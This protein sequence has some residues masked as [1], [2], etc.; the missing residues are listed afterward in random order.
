MP[1]TSLTP[2]EANYLQAS[3]TRRRSESNMIQPAPGMWTIQPDDESSLLDDNVNLL[4]FTPGSSPGSTASFHT[5]AANNN[6]MHNHM[7]PHPQRPPHM[8]H[9][10]TFGPPSSTAAH[11][12]HPGS[13][14]NSTGL[15]PHLSANLMLNS[16]PHM[17]PSHLS[18][19]F[20]SPMDGAVQLRRARSD[21]SR[22]HRQVRSEDFNNFT[23][24]GV[25]QDYP[26]FLAP[27]IG[28]SGM[29]RAGH[30]RRA[31]SGSRSDRGLGVMQGGMI[32]GVWGN[33]A[34]SSPYPSPNASPRGPVDNIPLPD[35]SIRRGQRPSNIQ[36]D[37]H[38]VVKQNVTTHATKDAS[39][40]RRKVEA[41]FVCPVPGCG[42]T[43]TRHFNLKGQYQ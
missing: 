27:D 33:S 13:A 31:S 14:S 11:L 26:Q 12:G 24:G 3:R 34:R 23:P 6:G 42:S 28:L 29:A 36:T 43:F 16:S 38:G 32:P 30:M 20:L 2:A 1:Q 22:G 10:Y 15:S 19:Q 25:Q 41:A 35:V 7:M 37:D 9:H 4:A 40:K 5:A 18:G 17:S 8:A 39:E 21:G